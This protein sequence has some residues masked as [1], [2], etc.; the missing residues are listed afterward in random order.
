AVVH[1]PWGAHPSMVQGYYNR[2]H[3]FF[4]DYHTRTRSVEGLQSWLDAWVLQVPTRAQYIEKLGKHRLY[5]LRVKEHR[6]A[7]SVDYGY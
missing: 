3:Q 4:A 6:Y 5:E 2:D 1:E 7:A